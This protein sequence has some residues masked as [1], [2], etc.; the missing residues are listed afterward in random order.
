RSPGSVRSA[1]RARC[2]SGPSLL[3]SS[4]SRGAR[5]ALAAD[6]TDPG[7]L[8]RVCA[9]VRAENYDLLVNNA[10]AGIYKPFRDTAWNEI[11][12]MTRLNCDAVMRLS[13]AY[14]ETAK[15]GGALINVASI[16][17]FTPYPAAAVYGAT[18]AFVLSLSESL[19]HQ[20]RGR[21]VYVMAL[22]PGATDTEFFEAAGTSREERPPRRYMQSSEAVAAAALRALKKRRDP[23]V[24]P[25]WHNKIFEV[26]MRLMGRKTLVRAV[27]KYAQQKSRG[28]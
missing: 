17:G 10:G 28:N 11:E 27:G 16:V 20:S 7:D 14:L 26:L 3:T 22:C 23:T 24:I 5:R 9:A 8:E 19:W 12:A 6:L 25:G 21:G 1:A 2:R 15:A 4:S 18:K 13:H